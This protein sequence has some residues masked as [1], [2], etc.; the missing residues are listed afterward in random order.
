MKRRYR[1]ELYEGRVNQIISHMPD[2][3]IGV[4]VIVGYPGETYEDFLRTYEFLNSLDIAYLHVF[5]YSERPNTIAAELDGVVPMEE[6]RRR[7][8]MLTIL[9]Q[10]KK[11]AFYK[12]F[13]ETEQPV[14]FESSKYDGIMTGFSHNY[15]KVAVPY[16]EKLLNT[17]QNVRLDELDPAQIR[18]SA[19]LVQSEE[20]A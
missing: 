1:T 10:K 19:S 5:T 18:F 6:R 4:D 20:I 15:L 2:A 8:K 13:A 17:I 16:Q 12:R 9:S 11:T 7:N 14:L 3:C